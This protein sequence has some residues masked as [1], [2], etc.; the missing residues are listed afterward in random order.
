M[1]SSRDPTTLL[2]FE[3]LEELQ[4]FR[5]RRFEWSV[6]ARDQIITD[7]KHFHHDYTDWLQRAK[8]II[9]TLNDEGKGD[10]ADKLALKLLSRKTVLDPANFRL[11]IPTGYGHEFW[12]IRGSDDIQDI[13]DKFESVLENHGHQVEPTLVGVKVEPHAEEIL[14]IH[15]ARQGSDLSRGPKLLS[16]AEPLDF[17]VSDADVVEWETIT[18]SDATKHKLWLSCTQ[19]GAV[20]CVTC[21]CSEMVTA[22]TSS[23]LPNAT[24]THDLISRHFHIDPFKDDNA[25]VHL[26]KV[27]RETFPGGVTEML[28][29]HG[30]R[31][32]PCHTRLRRTAR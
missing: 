13:R 30:R 32:T 9:A 26:L 27:H 17:E 20:F 28:Q 14:E 1:A 6:K 24:E 8:G 15:H 31:G 2:A 16:L 19:S 22:T 23:P 3:L 4:R 12:E 11:N 10:L 18:I 7:W 29:K 5:T 25:L 21:H